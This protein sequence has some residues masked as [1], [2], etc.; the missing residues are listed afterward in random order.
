VDKSFF[1]GRVQQIQADLAQLRA[2]KARLELEQTKGDT[3]PIAFEQV[4]ELIR[5]F[6]QVVAASPF[7][8]RKTLLHLF[9]KRITLTSDKQVDTIEL[10]F[11]EN[12]DSY[13]FSPSIAATT[14]IQRTRTKREKIEIAI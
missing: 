2:E 13:L 1:T 10:S 14:E 7:V 11:D 8:Q 12:L 3:S 4:R 6:S 5:G 9:I